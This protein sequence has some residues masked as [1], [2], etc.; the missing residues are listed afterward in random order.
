MRRL[1]IFRSR[2]GHD[3]D[4]RRR[5]ADADFPALLVARDCLDKP[6]EAARLDRD[7]V[8][9]ALEYDRADGAAVLAVL[10]RTDLDVFRTD[11]DIDRDILAKA[12][13]DARDVLA[14]EMDELVAH[15][16]AV[17]DVAVPDEVCDKGV[18]RLIVDALRRA[19]LL[20][21]ALVHDDDRVR[22]REG[23]FLVVRDEDEGDAELALDLDELALHALAQFEVER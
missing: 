9:R 8:D 19:D 7:I 12:R 1:L 15:H 10:R 23:L 4:V 14:Q 6:R 13:V 21:P 20:D 2:L 17:D 18:L 16:D 11:L 3:L 22:H 5:Q